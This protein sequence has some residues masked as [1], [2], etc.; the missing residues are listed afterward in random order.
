MVDVQA[1]M[2]CK[3]ASFSLSEKS[4][5]TR[6]MPLS[7]ARLLASEPVPRVEL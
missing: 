3:N 2:R 7:P 6:G 5:S 1:R 4:D